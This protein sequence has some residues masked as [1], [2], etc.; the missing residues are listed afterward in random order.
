[1]EDPIVVRT[2]NSRGEAE[3]ACSLLEAEGIT[4]AV[5][6]EERGGFTPSLDFSSGVPLVV[7]AADL[8]RARELL[9]EVVSD[10]EL[11]AAERESEDP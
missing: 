8:D 7:A 2:F 1:M 11:D 9:D 6:A 3:I 10:E 4:A 5:V